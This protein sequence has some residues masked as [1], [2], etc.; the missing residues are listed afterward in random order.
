M[1][2]AGLPMLGLIDV[3]VDWT[4]PVRTVTTAATVEVDIMPH[5]ARVAEGGSFD[6]Y[7]TALQDMGN[8]YVRF[9][10][11]Y[12]Y[13]KVAV[14]ELQKADCKGKG[15]SWNSTLLDE[16]TSDFMTAVC[17]PLAAN[18][19]CEK[20]LS[21]VPQLSTMPA[22]MYKS[23]GINRTAKMPDNPWHFPSGDFEYY[24]VAGQPLVDGGRQLL[25]R[26]MLEA[27]CCRQHG[28]NSLRQRTHEHHHHQR[29]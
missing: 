14:T 11:W 12:G 18:G 25:D 4:K 23:D 2:A 19:V 3:K 1:I 5:L 28:T 9:S 13:P 29:V 27:H 6:G 24:V 7:F 22:W 17:G 8:A 26:R 10:P 15:S 21:V 16:I 20:N